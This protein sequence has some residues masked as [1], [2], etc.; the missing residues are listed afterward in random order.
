M[1]LIRKIREN[2]WLRY[3]KDSDDSS[4]A[5]EIFYMIFKYVSIIIGIIIVITNIVTFVKV[6]FFPKLYL[7]EKFIELI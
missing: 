2:R 6:T 1:W 7:V 3:D 4:T 5:E